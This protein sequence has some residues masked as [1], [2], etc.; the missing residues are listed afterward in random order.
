MKERWLTSSSQEKLHRG[1]GR[2]REGGQ[3]GEIGDS[4]FE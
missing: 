4:E 3:G 1:Q 2:P